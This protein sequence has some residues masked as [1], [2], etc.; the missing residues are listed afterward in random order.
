MKVSPQLERRLVDMA[1]LIMAGVGVW[2]VTR[3]A[4]IKLDK[5]AQQAT[6]PVGKLISDLLAK[7]NGWE[8][9]TL[10]PLLIRDF[11][12]T[13]D[14]RLTPQAQQT[15]WSVDDYKPL[16]VELFTSQGGQL[17]EK[18]RPLINVEITRGNIDV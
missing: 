9:V 11:Y 8:P 7:F 18:Y 1:V 2:Y 5:A 10:Q 16:L 3:Q 14:H 12:L 17:K 13:S 4:A 6:E 15:L